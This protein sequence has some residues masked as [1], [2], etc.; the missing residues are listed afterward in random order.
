M[1]T[2]IA[3]TTKNIEN[4]NNS[5]KASCQYLYGLNLLSIVSLINETITIDNAIKTTFRSILTIIARV[6]LSIITPLKIQMP[7]F[8]NKLHISI[9][10][11]FLFF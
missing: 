11:S 3:I 7:V 2:T 9:I 8:Y 1:L 4:F 10:F 5:L 6:M